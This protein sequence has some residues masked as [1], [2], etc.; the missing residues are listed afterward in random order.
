MAPLPPGA[1]HP[2]GRG[3]HRLGTF[4]QNHQGLVAADGIHQGVGLTGPASLER[5]RPHQAAMGGT[6]EWI[7]NPLRLIRIGYKKSMEGVRC[8]GIYIYMYIYI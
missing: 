3:R 7:G 2:P 1:Q 5:L 8:V 4:G 6:W